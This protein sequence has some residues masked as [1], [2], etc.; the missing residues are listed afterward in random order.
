MSFLDYMLFYRLMEKISLDTKSDSNLQFDLHHSKTKEPFGLIQISH[1]MAEHKG[2]YVN[3]IN[4]LNQHGFHV[5][6]YDH[7]GHGDR[8]LNNQIGFFAIENGWNEV[9]DDLLAIHIETNKRFPNT[10]KIL[11]G[12]NLIKSSTKK[13]CDLVFPRSNNKPNFLNDVI[14]NSDFKL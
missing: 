12:N 6:I 14:L 3:F 9:V 11:L 10:P 4:Y 13:P 8:I 7:R 2:R 5:A 1:G